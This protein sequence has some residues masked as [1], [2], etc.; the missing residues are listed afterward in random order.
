MWEPVGP[1]PA[2]VYWKRRWLALASVIG[3]FVVCGLSVAA[4]TA[5][6]SPGG[7]EIDPAANRSALA[8]ETPGPTSA[9]PT[10]A[11]P[12]SAG[13]A[14]DGV[15][16]TSPD[17]TSPDSTSP[18]STSPDSTG[19]D[20]ASTSPSSTDPAL[21]VTGVP[22][23]TTT[24]LAEGAP[25]GTEVPDDTP[26]TPVPVAP[27]MPAPPSG[28]PPCTNDMILV[29]A[30]IDAA[31]HKVGDR[32]VLRLT[33]VNVSNQAC[34]RDLD[35]ALQEIVVWDRPIQQR[36]WSSNDCVNPSTQDIRTLVPGQP[37][38]FSVRWSGLSSN[39]GCTAPR[40]RL[41]AG[42]YTLL[43]RVDDKISGPTYFSLTP[44]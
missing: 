6:R 28:P 23:G 13:A 21:S 40:T 17:S 41:P 8:P 24:P 26:R 36:L 42:D 2:H 44:A 5:T 4:L 34:V 11:G 18:D 35:G 9:G 38:A 15:A 7:G 14:A 20:P 25:D 32:P 31:Q 27:T 16:T 39:P 22:A 12:T 19:P 43:T 3:V 30:E 37:V 1:L 10:S 33:V 29:G